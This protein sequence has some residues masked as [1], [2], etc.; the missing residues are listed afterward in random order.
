LEDEVLGS[1]FAKCIEN[2]III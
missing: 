1:K 2:D